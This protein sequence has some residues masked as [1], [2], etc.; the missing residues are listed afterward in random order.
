MSYTRPS[1]FPTFATTDIANGALG[2]N[3][4]VPADS[5]HQVYGWAY[6]EKPARETF[7]WLHRITNNWLL[8]LDQSVTSLQALLNPSV[9]KTSSDADNYFR[10]QW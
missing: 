2:G 5:T 9:N 4:V 6:G 3:N 1:A 7:N 8:Y 10:S